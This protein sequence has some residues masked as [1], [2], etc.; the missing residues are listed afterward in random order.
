MELLSLKIVFALAN[1][2]NPD[3]MPHYVC[4]WF[5]VFILLSEIH[6]LV[7]VDALCPSQQ[8]FSHVSMISCLPG[9]NQY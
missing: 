7:C 8:F 9:L 4:K 5:H 3:E 1:S 2:V 6:L